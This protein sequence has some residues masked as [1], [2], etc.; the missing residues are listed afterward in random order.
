M[1]V[2]NEFDTNSDSIFIGDGSLAILCSN[3]ILEETLNAIDES[4]PAGRKFK[5]I[6][7]LVQTQQFHENDMEQ[8]VFYR[9]QNT[10]NLSSYNDVL[11]LVAQESFWPPEYIWLNGEFYNTS[12]C[13]SVDDDSSIRGVQW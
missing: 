10:T 5:E 9:H 12:L 6:E 2:K 1:G 7:S 11:R 13:P 8:L 4:D 3:D